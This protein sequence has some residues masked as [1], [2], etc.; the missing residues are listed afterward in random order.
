MYTRDANA[1][2]KNVTSAAAPSSRRRAL[3]GDV[4]SP[5]L[6][7][8]PLH[9][10]HAGRRRRRPGG[11]LL[12]VHVLVLVHAAEHVP[13]GLEPP[14]PAASSRALRSAPLTCRNAPAARDHGLGCIA[15]ADI[16]GVG[17]DEGKGGGIV[18]S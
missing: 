13:R 15:P 12:E 11:V 17:V 2:S 5:P 16:V 1:Q 8:G 4:T 3:P 7:R 18:E 9:R 14:P 10:W 6:H